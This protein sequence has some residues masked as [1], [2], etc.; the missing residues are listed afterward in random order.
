MYKYWLAQ[1]LL[2]VLEAFWCNIKTHS[3]IK[4]LLLFA[5][6]KQVY[7]IVSLLYL[8]SSNCEHETKI[9]DSNISYYILG[10]FWI[11]KLA[12]HYKVYYLQKKKK[13]YLW[14][15]NL[16]MLKWFI[17]RITLTNGK[18]VPC[19]HNIH[20]PLLYGP[21]LAMFRKRD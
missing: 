13:D 5:P 7:F 15:L 9:S 16:R 10:L 3:W 1:Y 17:W 19:D 18:S 12:R 11:S 6:F 8:L 2:C 14:D 4:G 20:E 21:T